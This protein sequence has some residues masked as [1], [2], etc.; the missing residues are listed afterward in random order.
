MKMTILSLVFLLFILNGFALSQQELHKA[1]YKG[2]I[3]LVRKLLKNNPDPNERDTF[4]GTALHAAMF[5]KNVAVIQ[6][7][8]DHGFDV[9]VQGLSNGYTPLHDA[10]WANNLSAVKLLLKH[11]AKV[12]IKGKDGLT[13]Y[14]KAKQEGRDEI[15]EYFNSK[16]IGN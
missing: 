4:G 7:L 9:N 15:V 5:Q 16:G 13:P 1:A 8:I 10:V 3:E 2:D 14:A 12:D 11:G 6:I